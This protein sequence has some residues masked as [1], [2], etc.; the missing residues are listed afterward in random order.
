MPSHLS[1]R[2]ANQTR[3]A[4][5]PFSL[6]DFGIL[7]S[8]ALDVQRVPD[9]A[10]A[11]SFGA[12]IAPPARR[13]RSRPDCSDEPYG[14]STRSL[15]RFRGAFVKKQLPQQAQ[16]NLQAPKQIQKLASTSVPHLSQTL[17][18]S[19]SPI[20]P[21]PS[22]SFTNLSKLVSDGESESPSPR[23]SPE[24]CTQMPCTPVSPRK[25]LYMRIH[26][27]LTS[28]SGRSSQT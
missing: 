20:P 10:L 1:P 28:V 15:S 17:I 6:E 16:Q 11:F 3:V 25:S 12:D 13:A 7:V 19:S 9:S 22:A 5:Q 18:T 8:T 24:P 26:S 27:Q 4:E 23:L 21:I 14:Q 2:R